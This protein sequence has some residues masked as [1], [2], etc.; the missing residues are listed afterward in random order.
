LCLFGKW[1]L[2]CCISCQ[3]FFLQLLY[4]YSIFLSGSI[5][6]KKHVTFRVEPQIVKKFKFLAVE[7]DKTLT[8]TDQENTYKKS[9]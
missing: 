5:M 7:H 9:V 6:D 3:D 4:L 8:D 2:Y 1:A